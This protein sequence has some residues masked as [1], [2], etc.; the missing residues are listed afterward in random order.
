MKTLL[1]ITIIAAA[2]LYASAESFKNQLEDMK[3][4]DQCV[5]AKIAAGVERSQIDVIG[6]KC[7]IK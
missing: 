7:F 6:A 4:A 5:A 2:S 1:L 3:Q